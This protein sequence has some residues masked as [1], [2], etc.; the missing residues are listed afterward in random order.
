MNTVCRTQEAVPVGAWKAVV[1]R[2]VCTLEA[3]HNSF[4]RGAVLA[5]GLEA[6]PVIFSAKNLDTVCPSPENLPE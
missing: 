6:I 3:Q 4:Q 2:T 1:L 5:T